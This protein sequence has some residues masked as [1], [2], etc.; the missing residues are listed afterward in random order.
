MAAGNLLAL[1]RM[2]RTLAQGGYDL[3][4]VH[5]PIASLITR[6]AAASLGRRRPAIVYTAHV[7]TSSRA[8]RVSNAGY[9]EF[10]L[11]PSEPIT[12]KRHLMEQA[13]IEESAP[14]FA[15]TM[16]TDSPD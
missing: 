10:A 8:V 4:H 1:H 11:R 7:S 6:L 16:V 14:T 5:T 3:V 12:R 2:R 9:A 15:R 13:L